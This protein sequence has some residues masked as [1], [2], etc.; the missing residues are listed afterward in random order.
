MKKVFTSLLAILFV[1]FSMAVLSYARAIHIEKKLT[2]MNFKEAVG[3]ICSKGY[4]KQVSINYINS[5]DIEFCSEI[6][7][8]RNTYAKNVIYLE[9]FRIANYSRGISL[10]FGNSST[11]QVVEQDYLE[12]FEWI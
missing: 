5:D 3:F 6:Y 4:L 9:T 11:S 10:V 8:T 12:G 7:L 2:D 1:L